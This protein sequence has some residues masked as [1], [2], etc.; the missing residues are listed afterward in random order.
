MEQ[1]ASTAGAWTLGRHHGETTLDRR[2]DDELVA[3]AQRGQAA[4][5]ATIYR[6]HHHD[7][8]AL[9]R[10]LLGSRHDAEDAVQQTFLA[11]HRDLLTRRQPV[12]LRPWLRTI[13]RNHC[14]S[15]LRARRT[16][17]QLSESAAAS[18]G[19]ATVVQLREETRELLT[20][21]AHLPGDQRT[22]LLLAEV[23]EL[24]HAEVAAVVDCRPQKV[25]ALV[26]QARATLDAMREA[27][28]IP[29]TEIRDQLVT[30]A[31]ADL[32]RGPLRRHLAEC[33]SCRRFQRALRRRRR[34]PRLLPAAAL[35]AQTHIDAR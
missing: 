14:I 24:D 22:A 6:R 7:V 32:R 17:A 5:F 25:K 27:R 19:P 29:C 20:D 2:D 9:C 15:L 21:L 31:G 34:L 35:K 16:H 33:E 18:D 13:A 12:V 23:C 11:A 10:R 4:A 30:A 26:F 1:D 28:A 8:D 3:L